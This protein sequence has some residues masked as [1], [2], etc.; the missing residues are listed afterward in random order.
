[1]PPLHRPR[2]KSNAAFAVGLLLVGFGVLAGLP[3]VL[4]TPPP[5][6]AEIRAIGDHNPDPLTPGQFECWQGPPVILI[7]PPEGPP[8]TNLYGCWIDAAETHVQVGQTIR[9]TGVSHYTPH[10]IHCFGR[11]NGGF[12][13]TG[14][15]GAGV[16]VDWTFNTAGT[17]DVVCAFH[18]EMTALLVVES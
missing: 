15:I 13:D 12:C 18:P 11:D 8:I 4:A 10:K 5:V 7:E 17:Y 9:F 6:A 1:M 3:G 14:P 16:S 2:W